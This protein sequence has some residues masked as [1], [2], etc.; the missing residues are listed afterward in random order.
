MRYDA[1]IVGDLVSEIVPIF[2]DG[3]SEETQNGL[4]ELFLGWI[5]LIVGD[6]GVHD[7]PKA[8]DGVQMW[9]IGG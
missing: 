1:K 8:L 3:F 2:R 7:S 5:K 6:V 9:A 4:G